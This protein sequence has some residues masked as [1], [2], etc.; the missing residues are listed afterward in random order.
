MMFHVVPGT[1]LRGGG[2]PTPAN[3]L[4]GAVQ[5]D[6]SFA[7]SCDRRATDYPRLWYIDYATEL[8]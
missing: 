6:F 8:S 4:A 5:N 1:V 7:N 3:E 2:S